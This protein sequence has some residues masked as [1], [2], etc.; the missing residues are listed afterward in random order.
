MRTATPAC[1]LRTAADDRAEARVTV[2]RAHNPGWWGA[3][4]AIRDNALSAILRREAE[5]VYDAICSLPRDDGDEMNITARWS[6]WVVAGLAL[7]WCRDGNCTL[8]QRATLLD[9]ARA[10][11]RLALEVAQ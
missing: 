11:V 10:L 7:K 4:A 9:A 3:S 5:A 6:A 8:S 2:D 1:L